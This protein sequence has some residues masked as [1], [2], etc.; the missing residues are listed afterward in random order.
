M[1]ST[2]NMKKL[3]LEPIV[4]ARLLAVGADRLPLSVHRGIHASVFKACTDLINDL[5]TPEYV[6]A[7]VKQALEAPAA[8]TSATSTGAAL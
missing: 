5:I 8:A 4:T 2:T 1:T 6:G 7:Q 3:N